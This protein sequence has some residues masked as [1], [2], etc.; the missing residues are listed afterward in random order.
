MS[1]PA[2]TT[3]LGVAAKILVAGNVEVGVPAGKTTVPGYNNVVLSLSGNNGQTTFQLDP[4][5]VDVAN[6]PVVP[7]TSY[8]LTQVAAS[9]GPEQLTV[10]A[11]AAS[12]G[13]T[14]VYTVTSGGTTN[15]WVGYSFTVAGFSDSTNNGD[16]VATASSSTTL[17]LEN[18]FAQAETHAATATSNE[19]VAVYTG[20]IVETANS[21]IGKTF[22]V[23][24]FSDTNNNGTFIATANNGTTTITLANPN[25]TAQS[26]Q[27]ATAKEQEA[28][29]TDA[30]ASVATGTGVYTGTFPEYASFP[31]GGRVTITGFVTNPANNGTFIISA[32]TVSTLTTSN[33]A[34]V[35]ESASAT[36]KIAPSQTL[37]YFSDGTAQLSGYS[38]TGPNTNLSTRVPVVSVSA[39]GLITAGALGESVVEVSFPAYA[40]KIGATGALAPNPMAGLPLMKIYA[41]VN[42]TVVS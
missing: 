27:T 42:V 21:L 25:T 39:N 12:S 11:V 3:G 8:A 14:A 1:F 29:W 22:V 31:I 15:Q 17:T 13:G 41:E 20:T 23:A 37:T 6:V 9:S 28:E 7:G 19:G 24:G 35:S 36:A 10:S 4:Q 5:V 40:N 32:A 2:P 33:T 30:V 16:F 34:S 26:G 18:P 38:A